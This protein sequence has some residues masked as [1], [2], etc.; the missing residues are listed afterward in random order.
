MGFL[1]DDGE[2]EAVVYEGGVGTV[3]N[4]VVDVL[5]FCGSVGGLDPE[6]SARVKD[7]GRVGLPH[8]L[9]RDPVGAVGEVGR[10]AGVVGVFI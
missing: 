9:K 4:S 7:V 6:R 1:Q 5:C 3:L 10:G 8:V 2:D